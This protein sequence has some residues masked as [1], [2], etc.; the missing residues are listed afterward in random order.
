MVKLDQI[1]CYV[2][3][4]SILVILSLLTLNAVMTHANN[5]FRMQ[6]AVGMNLQDFYCEDVTRAM[7]KAGCIVS[8]PMTGLPAI[9]G[10]RVECR[11]YIEDETECQEEF[12][13]RVL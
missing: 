10:S 12:S 11:E 9:D 8:D 6:V 5:T 4:G 3:V 7:A 2:Y 1:R 13:D